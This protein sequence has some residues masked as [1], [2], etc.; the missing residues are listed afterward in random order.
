MEPHAVIGLVMIGALLIGVT[1][2]A[3]LPGLP[4]KPKDPFD[5]DPREPLGKGE[6]PC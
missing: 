6:K 3:W 1:L 4:E 2:D 5:E